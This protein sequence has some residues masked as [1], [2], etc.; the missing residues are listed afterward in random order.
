MQLQE[1]LQIINQPRNAA[2]NNDGK[3]MADKTAFAQLSS[4][5]DQL[6]IQTAN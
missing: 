6:I 1:E 4:S 3:E 2:F 5:V